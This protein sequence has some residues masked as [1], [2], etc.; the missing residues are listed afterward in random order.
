MEIGQHTEQLIAFLLAR[1][2]VAQ[3]LESSSLSLRL[4]LEAAA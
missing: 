4:Q 3:A 2:A 1:E